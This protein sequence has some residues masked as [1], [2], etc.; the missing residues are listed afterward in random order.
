M[1]IYYMKPNLLCTVLL[2]TVTLPEIILGALSQEEL[3]LHEFPYST[4]ALISARIPTLF[5]NLIVPYAFR[6]MGDK[7]YRNIYRDSY[8]C[9]KILGCFHTEL[10]NNVQ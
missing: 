8:V 9:S 4:L 6:N 3:K 5:M 2:L 7:K 1:S 10:T